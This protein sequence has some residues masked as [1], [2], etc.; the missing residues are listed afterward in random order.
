M[1]DFGIFRLELEKNS[2]IWNQHP[3]IC[4]ITKLRGKTKMPKFGTKIA[5]FGYFWPKKPYLDIF[6]LEF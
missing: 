2:H 3:Q 5:L 6:E 1:P 4:L